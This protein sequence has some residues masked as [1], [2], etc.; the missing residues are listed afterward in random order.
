MLI[1]TDWLNCI[2]NINKAAGP[3][4]VSGLKRLGLMSGMILEL[5]TKLS[6]PIKRTVGGPVLKNLPTTAH[7]LRLGDFRLGKYKG[8]KATRETAAEIISPSN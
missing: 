6:A 7:V 8:Q 1:Q 5:S 3:S 4:K 2:L